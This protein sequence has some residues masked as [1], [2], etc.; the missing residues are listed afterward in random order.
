MPRFYFDL[1]HESDCVYDTD[2]IVLPDAENA[3]AQALEVLLE[4][5]CDG[6]DREIHR[7]ESRRIVLRVSDE[8]DRTILLAEVP[9]EQRWVH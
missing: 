6:I 8:N 2:G 4:L 3:R 9:Q 5:A 1:Q 7:D